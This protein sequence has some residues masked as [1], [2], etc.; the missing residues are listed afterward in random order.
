VCDNPGQAIG[1]K[2]RNPQR[3]YSR[4]ETEGLDDG[5]RTSKKN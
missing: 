4:G 2:I 5:N 3:I 1:R